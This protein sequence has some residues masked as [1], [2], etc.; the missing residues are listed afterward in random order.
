MPRLEIASQEKEMVFELEFLF[1]EA[2]L[3]FKR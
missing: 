3:K 2:Q 1:E